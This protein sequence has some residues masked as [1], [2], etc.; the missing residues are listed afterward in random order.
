MGHQ[1]ERHEWEDVAMT[2]VTE[3]KAMENRVARE[4][5]PSR[6][7]IQ[8]REIGRL[9]YT[10]D[11]AEQQLA[12]AAAELV[13]VKTMLHG[14]TIALEAIDGRRKELEAL[15]TRARHIIRGAHL[16][17]YVTHKRYFHPLTMA[18]PACPVCKALVEM[19]RSGS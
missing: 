13:N 15:L 11:R 18:T 3:F 8:E 6:E 5:A 9:K 10:R 19:E 2:T 4:G 16:K 12:E 7:Q 14:K 1:P 17:H